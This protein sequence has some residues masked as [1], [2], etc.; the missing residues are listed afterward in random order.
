MSALDRTKQ[1][2]ARGSLLRKLDLPLRPLE[3]FAEKGDEILDLL[4]VKT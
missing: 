1:T 2:Q 4:L 3:R